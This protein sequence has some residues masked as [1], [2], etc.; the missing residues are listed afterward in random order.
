M[1][2]RDGDDRPALVGDVGARAG[3]AEAGAA[4]ASATRR[5]PK[6]K[7]SVAAPM[8][9]VGRLIAPMLAPRLASISGRVWPPR[10]DAE[11]V[12]QLARRD[13]DARGG[14][15]ARDHRMAEE[16]RE[17]AEP[18]HPHRDQH[19]PREERER[20]RRAEVSPP[21][22]RS[23]RPPP[24]SSA[25]SPPPARPRAS[26]WC[27]RRVGDERQ[28]AGVEPDLPAAARRA[29]RRRATAGSA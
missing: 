7:A 20:H 11:D 2:R 28:D 29:S 17:K 26:G 14:D 24:P 21:G 22:S 4:A 10:L 15:E 8:A 23:G 3:H 12:P 5:D 9:R 6:R 18:Q 1:V 16:V 25:R 13:Q 27:R 19:Q